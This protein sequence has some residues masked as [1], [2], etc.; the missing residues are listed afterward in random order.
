MRIPKRYG[1]SKDQDCPFCGKQGTTSNPQGV[2]V[3]LDHKEEYVDLKCACG[4]WLEVKAGK[5]GPY[6]ICINCG[7]INFA[8]AMD[9]NPD[10]R[11][12]FEKKKSEEKIT[13]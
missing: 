8:K 3:C 13:C 7:N 5:W 1:E 10:F 6:C 9:M 4:S 12:K 2:P 11:E